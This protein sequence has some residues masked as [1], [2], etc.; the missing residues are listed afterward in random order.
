MG[1]TNNTN[2]AKNADPVQAAAEAAAQRTRERM[3]RKA[4]KDAKKWAEFYK[5]HSHVV[6]GSVRE[7]T[8]ADKAALDH[9][10]GRVCDIKC[11]DTGE[12]RTIN[13]Q[14]AFQVKRS[15]AAQKVHLKKQRATRRAEKAAARKARE[16]NES[17]TV[18]TAAKTAAKTEAQAKKAPRRRGNGK[19]TN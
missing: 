1:N 2:T 7:P 16:A 9:I 6:D 11:V 18:Q 8:D 14:D 4:E 10:H 5:K 19:T 13:V 15:V 12:L 3:Q 17:T